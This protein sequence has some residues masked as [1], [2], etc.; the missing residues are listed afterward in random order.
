M[1][2]Q[3]IYSAVDLGSFQFTPRCN[4]FNWR[5]LHGLD[6]DALVRGSQTAA[7]AAPVCVAAAKALIAAT[8]TSCRCGCTTQHGWRQ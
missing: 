2:K 3:D 4:P 7:V 6:V 5:L 8:H 1:K